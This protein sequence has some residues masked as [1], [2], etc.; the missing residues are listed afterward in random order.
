[1]NRILQRVA[2]KN[3]FCYFHFGKDTVSE[4][5]YLYKYKTK[6]YKTRLTYYGVKSQC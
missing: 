4:K 3:V 2:I 1:M 5:N 6:L